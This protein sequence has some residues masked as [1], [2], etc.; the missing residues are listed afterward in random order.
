MNLYQHSGKLGYSPVLLPLAG[1]P[2][3]LILA[4]IYGYINV[5]N[6]I[7]GYIT[8]LI[9][10]GYAFACGFVVAALLKFGKARSKTFCLIGGAVGAVLSL[11]FA[12]AF[13]LYALVHRFGVADA[14]IFEILLSPLASW[15]LITE[16]NKTGW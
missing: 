2:L 1:I 14:G 8:F 15:E 16:I 7:G 10:L 13:F 3:L 12:W 4:C 6:P 9:V 11:Y 5:Y